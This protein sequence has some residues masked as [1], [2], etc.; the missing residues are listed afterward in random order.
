MKKVYILL[1]ILALVTVLV[2]GNSNSVVSENFSN[3]NPQ[4]IVQQMQQKMQQ[5][6][7]TIQQQSEKRIK[8]IQ[9]NAQ[10]AFR[11]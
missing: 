7:K 5:Q 8:T 10:I 9:Q 3:Q 1:A 4:D 11:S 2:M 6:I